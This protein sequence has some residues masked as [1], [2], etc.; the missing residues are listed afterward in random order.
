MT[1]AFAVHSP[2]CG[3]G[4][5]CPSIEFWPEPGPLIAGWMP[6]GK[7]SRWLWGVVG[8]LDKDWDCLARVAWSGLLSDESG[9]RGLQAPGA[10][11]C[12]SSPN[13][14]AGT[15]RI[16]KVSRARTSFKKGGWS[17]CVVRAPASPIWFL[18][19][20]EPLLMLRAFQLLSLLRSSTRSCAYSSP[21]ALWAPAAPCLP[22]W[23]TPHSTTRTWH[24]KR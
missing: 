21:H 8:G 18:P 22:S 2:H 10:H 20:S 24:W 19:V 16:P 13:S 3:L 6:G 1:C 11:R 17:V 4:R 23:E 7:A 15:C 14:S 12:F 9:R 5:S